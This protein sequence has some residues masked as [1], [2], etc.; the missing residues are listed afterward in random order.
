MSIYKG[1]GDHR[2]EELNDRIASRSFPPCQVAPK[3]TSVDHFAFASVPTRGTLFPAVLQRN[4]DGD[5]DGD[6][7]G[8]DA[9]SFASK[10]DAEMNLRNQFFGLQRGGVDQSCYVPP[11]SSDLYCHHYSFKW[12]TP[13]PAPAPD[14][15]VLGEIVVKS[16]PEPSSALTASCALRLLHNHTR[17]QLR[18][19]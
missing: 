11:S 17:T 1:G 2:V 9:C 14:D 16:A 3:K 6:G 18:N 5:G 10:V 7:D 8:K 4:G 12:Q 15:G 13:A 19:L